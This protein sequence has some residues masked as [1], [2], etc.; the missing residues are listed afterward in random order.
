[1]ARI[2]FI[3]I[4]LVVLGAGGAFVWGGLFP[5]QAQSLPVSHDI[6][7]ATATGS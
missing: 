1:M 5:P 6:A 4:A 2:I 7:P 3:L